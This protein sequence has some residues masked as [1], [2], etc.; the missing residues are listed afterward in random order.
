M[1]KWTSRK[2]LLA[3][4]GCLTAL[5]GALQE[6]ISWNDALIVMVPLI[7]VYIF[8]ESWVDKSRAQ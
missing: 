5:A 2:F 6:I 3:F 8:G 4:G 7:G 1:S